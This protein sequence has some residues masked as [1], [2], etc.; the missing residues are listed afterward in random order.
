[1]ALCICHFFFTPLIR[2]TQI[3]CA[4]GWLQGE[5]WLLMTVPPP[6]PWLTLCSNCVET[7]TLCLCILATIWFPCKLTEDQMGR[8]A[9]QKA[10]VAHTA[11]QSSNLWQSKIPVVCRKRRS[12]FSFFTKKF[13]PKGRI[14]PETELSHLCILSS[15]WMH[16]LYRCDMALWWGQK[17]TREASPVYRPNMAAVRSKASPVYRPNMA[18]V[19]SKAL[20]V[21][22]PNMALWW[23]QRRCLSTDLTWCC[24]EVEGI[25]CLQTWHGSKEVKGTACLQA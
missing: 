6:L 8:S 7:L 18:A 13:L 23:G 16:V 19:R 22:R 2:V 25:T 20:P 3:T 5:G 11:Y 4:G 12:E 17:D 15:A 10:P 21:Y 24:D 9:V 14:H 1:M